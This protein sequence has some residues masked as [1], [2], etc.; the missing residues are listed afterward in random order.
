MEILLVAAYS[1]L[2]VYIIRKSRF[3][4]VENFSAWILPSFF[5]V[6]CISGILLGLIYT[7]YY[8]NHSDADTF[9]FFTDSNFIYESLWD[10]PYDFFR[11]FTGIYGKDSDLYVYYIKMDAWLNT[12]PLYN[13]NRTMIRLNAFFRF[14]SLGYYN[15]HVIFLNFI[16][17]TGL[18]CL[19]KTFSVYLSE[20]KLELIFLLFLMPSLIFWG[21]GLLKDGLLI[22]ATGFMLYSFQKI[23]ETGITVRRILV[24]SVS[25]FVLAFIKVYVMVL[26]LPGLLAWFLTRKKNGW[27]VYLTFLGLYTLFFII[28]FNLYHFNDE[29]NVAALLFYKQKNFI[30]IGMRHAAKMI[31]VVGYECSGTSILYHAPEAFAKTLFRPFLW[32]VR[33]N[34]MIL[35]SALEN[36]LLIIMTI[37]SLITSNFHKPKIPAVIFSF[38][39]VICLFVL[40]SLITPVLG[41]IVRYR[42][43]GLPFLIFVLLYYYDREKMKRIFHIKRISKSKS[44]PD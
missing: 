2:F 27:K 24:F 1:F 18:F 21:S 15:V 4:Y 40:I 17:F 29:Y 43:I 23:M 3:F 19:Y 31:S 28:A 11:M 35:L 30:E 39:F 7:H 26:M 12:S 5:I 6:K 38:I 9:K 8:K 33:G 20:K 13:D 25:I 34:P 14:F 10:K 36:I 32:D 16:S 44:Q 37:V 41:A 22:T 42:I